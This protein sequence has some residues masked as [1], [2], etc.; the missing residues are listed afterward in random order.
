MANTS[1]SIC[2]NALVKLGDDPIT[3]L[4][5]PT[6]RARHCNRLFTPTLE[7]VLREANWNDSIKRARLAQ[8][9][10]EPVWEFDYAYSLPSDYMKMVKTSLDEDKLMYKIE[11]GKLLTNESEVYL[12]Y[13]YNNSNVASYDSLHVETLTF[14]MA[15]ALANAI[16]GKVSHA[17]RMEKAFSDSLKKARLSDATVS[18]P[19]SYA[20]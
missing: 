15:F 17:D 5:D 7:A 6:T 20:G 18:R 12:A 4:T 1:V 11:N 14:A 10:T 13:V 2:S 19:V 9:V 16:T 3:S 8:L